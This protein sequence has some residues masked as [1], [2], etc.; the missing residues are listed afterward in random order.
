MMRNKADTDR[1]K[2]LIAEIKRLE[3]V[4]SYIIYVVDK[5]VVKIA[6]KL[7]K[8]TKTGLNSIIKLRSW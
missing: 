8:S 6:D 2:Y 1:E 4:S 7:E 3:I 5:E